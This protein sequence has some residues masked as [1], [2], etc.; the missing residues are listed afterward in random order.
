MTAT[1]QLHVHLN[2]GEKA[3]LAAAARRQ[4][5]SVPAY[6]RNRLFDAPLSQADQILLERLASLRP[7]F[8]A[9]LK[10]INANLAE[11]ADLRQQTATPLPPMPDQDELASIADH[12]CLPVEPSR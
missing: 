4:N 12:L 7:R 10:T 1:G 3:V 8:E 2:T 5:L 9:A 11:I 6:I